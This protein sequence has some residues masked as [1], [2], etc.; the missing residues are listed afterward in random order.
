MIIIQATP[1]FLQYTL[2]NLAVFA[3]LL[4]IGFAIGTLVALGQ[5]YGHPVIAALATA[6]AWFFRGVPALVLLFLFYYGPPVF[7]I[8]IEPFTAAAL[9]MGFRSSGYQSQIFRG[10]IESVPAGQMVAGRAIGMSR[11]QT[12]WSIVLPQAFRL[13]LPAWTNEFSAVLKDTTLVYAIGINEVMRFAR[14]IY[15]ARPELAI[16]TF[17]F[18]ALIFWVLTVIGT[19]LLQR[20]E[21]RLALPGLEGRMRGPRAVA[22]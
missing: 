21:R 15:V 8:N 14:T 11:L 20:L 3:V 6:W 2:I 7:N 10:A 19:G 22:K 13:A 4:P 18:V 16:L 12:V 17:L 5:V 9:A 1:T